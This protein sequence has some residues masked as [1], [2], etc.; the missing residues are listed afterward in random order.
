MT[1]SRNKGKRG[2]LAFAAYLR[3]QGFSARRGQQFAGRAVGG[4][5]QPD[6]C[7]S[8]PGVHWEVK[9][10]ASGLRVYP[11]LAQAEAD[12]P[13]GAAG[14]VAYRRASK[15]HRGLPWVA[16]LHMDDLLRLIYRLE[17]E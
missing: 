13:E 16:V 2:E 9:H 7:S 17:E 10:L 12:A 6:V 5:E 11:A 1:H 15:A 3:E 4:E 14:I 8:V